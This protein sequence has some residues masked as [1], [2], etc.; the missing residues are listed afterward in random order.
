VKRAAWVTIFGAVLTTVLSC[1]EQSA[2]QNQPTTTNKPTAASQPAPTSQPAAGGQPATDSTPV[3]VEERR[4]PLVLERGKPQQLPGDLQVEL[5]SYVIEEIVAEEGETVGDSAVVTLKVG[6]AKLTLMDA[7]EGFGSGPVAWIGPHRF[8][9]R[10]HMPDKVDLYIDRLANTA[11][12]DSARTVRVARR[13][14]VQLDGDLHLRFVSHGHKMVMKGGPP[15][16]L[17]VSVEYR[18]QTKVADDTTAAQV[19]DSQ[20]YYLHPPEEATWRWR[21]YRFRLLQ[22]EYD[23]WMKL[24]VEQLRLDAVDGWA[25]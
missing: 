17:M 24:E 1:R 21:E 9:L 12:A 11:V 2:A 22:H 5:L 8:T 4:A 13:E 6:A 15:S 16:P 23:Q 19:L 18:Q 14:S 3:A 25:S 20:T 10:D 7:P